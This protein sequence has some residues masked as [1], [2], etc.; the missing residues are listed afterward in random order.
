V[1]KFVK[2]CKENFTRLLRP[3][4]YRETAILDNS[5]TKTGHMRDNL[6]FSKNTEGGDE[7]LAV[8]K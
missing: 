2:L 3:S 5:G 7:P 8:K 6:V 4:S 1:K